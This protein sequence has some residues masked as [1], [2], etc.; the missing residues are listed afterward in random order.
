MF[1]WIA[2]IRESLQGRRP[3]SLYLSKDKAE[4]PAWLAKDV[5]LEMP[6]QRRFERETSCSNTVTVPRS[7][8]INP[9]V[10]S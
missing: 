9:G 4:W 5:C 10:Q 8:Q 6:E 1:E 2:R 7:C 3:A